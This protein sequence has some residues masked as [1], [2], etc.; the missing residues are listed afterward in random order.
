[1]GGA[2]D[3]HN[4]DSTQIKL[5][6]A[7]T[8][9]LFLITAG[10]VIW[11][12]LSPVGLRAA[13]DNNAWSIDFIRQ[14]YHLPGSRADLP[15][16]PVTHANAGLLLSRKALLAGDYAQ[17]LAYI[18]PRTQ[19]G[20]PLALDTYAQVQYLD[21]DLEGAVQTWI[22]LENK[23]TLEQLANAMLEQGRTDLAILCF[24][25]L[26]ELNPEK[27]TSSLAVTY[28]NNELFAEAIA[29]FQQSIQDYPDS[30]YKVHWLRYLGDIYARQQKY[31]EAEATYLQ[32]VAT[33]PK[34]LR[35]WRNLG[36]MYS[37][38][39]KEYE[40]A[41]DCFEKTIELAPDEISG[42]LWAAGAYEQAGL[43]DKALQT[44]QAALEIDSANADALAGVKRM[45]GAD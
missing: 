1:M 12:I 36:L 39:L 23:V 24:R 35:S 5:I 28:K 20:D 8:L 14:Y 26:Y 16:P 44:Y 38:S 11:G 42:Y 27:Y 31:A 29:L 33:D 15:T 2:R 34:D 43:T 30:E 22:Q 37:G 25:K 45:T 18:A 7:T 9:F 3:Q 41:A 40:K 6:K 21:G 17:A 4:P 10:I 13:L 32:A 19:S